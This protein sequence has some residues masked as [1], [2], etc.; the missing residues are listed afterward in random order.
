MNY[1]KNTDK[2][3]HHKISLHFGLITTKLSTVNHYGK[4][5]CTECN[6]HVKWLGKSEI[7]DII[8]YKN[9][10][11]TY[12]DFLKV[13]NQK[14]Y[15]KPDPNTTIYLA[16]GYKNRHIAKKND[17]YYDTVEKLWYTKI[18]NPKN[19]K[20]YDYMMPDDKLWAKNYRIINWIE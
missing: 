7:N 14:I 12:Y 1:T 19:N 6:K 20:L 16:I 15:I 5:T 3:L 17:C 4:I 2:H 9:L 10:I 18:D 13:K 11:K 8:P